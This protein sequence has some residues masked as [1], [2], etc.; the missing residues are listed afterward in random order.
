M[1]QHPRIA[2]TASTLLGVLAVF[3]QTNVRAQGPSAG[4]GGIPRTEDE[5]ILTEN[6]TPPPANSLPNRV[7]NGEVIPAV[8][9]VQGAVDPAR[10]LGTTGVDGA[11]AMDPALRLPPA[12]QPLTRAG[13]YPLGMDSAILAEHALG[14][15]I[16]GSALRTIA[17][18]SRVGANAEQPARTL[19]THADRLRTESQALLNRAAGDSPDVAASLPAR[20]FNLAARDY[21]ATLAAL[22]AT[23]NVEKTQVALINHAVKQV[24]DADH[25]RQMG[26]AV[27]G[28]PA[29]QQLMT[30]ASNMKNEGT[31]TLL[32]L[33]RVDNIWVIFVRQ[34]I[35]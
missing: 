15:A 22:E 19:L 1:R 13:A 3:G 12:P 5:R 29:M 9:P 24:L 26:R 10:S 32:K 18:R 31:Q 11:R 7:A 21:I 4:L 20:K 34:V 30:H 17:E 23:N 27:S 6:P 8:P 28:S 35:F 33:G 2:L 25:I 16:E 14:M